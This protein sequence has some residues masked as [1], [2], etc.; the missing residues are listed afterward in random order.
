MARKLDVEYFSIDLGRLEEELGDHAKEFFL[1]S[2]ALD[3]A[4]E[5]LERAKAAKEIAEDELK[6]AVA[7]IELDIRKDPEKYDL[8]KA[9][10]ISAVD[11]TVLLQS[12]Y[13]AAKKKVYEAQERLIEAQARV[14]AGTTA[15]KTMDQRGKAIGKQVDLFI[16][17][18]WAKPRT[19]GKGVNRDRLDE[20]KLDQRRE[21]IKN[22]QP[23]RGEDD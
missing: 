15:V 23:K 14:H 18:Y 8:G 6:L 2:S 12:A 9:P 20:S 13:R 21:R 16:S 19:G 3:E 5:H 22:S 4:L 11:K 1:L 17:G 7:K 10:V